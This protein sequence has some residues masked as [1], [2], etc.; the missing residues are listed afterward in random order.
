MTIACSGYWETSQ[1]YVPSHDRYELPMMLSFVIALN[2]LWTHL[3]TN[4]SV[5]GMEYFIFLPSTKWEQFSTVAR[6]P[7]SHRISRKYSAWIAVENQIILASLALVD[8]PYSVVPHTVL[9]FRP[10]ET[11]ALQLKRSSGSSS[12]RDL[13]SSG[14]LA[15][16]A[17]HVKPRA[18]YVMALQYPILISVSAFVQTARTVITALMV[19]PTIT[20]CI[21]F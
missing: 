19:I 1:R 10:T 18:G 17:I 2:N 11:S 14:M 21:L 15:V 13:K 7:P 6:K 4:T 9:P 3:T 5:A 8:C 16:L 20:F 12:R